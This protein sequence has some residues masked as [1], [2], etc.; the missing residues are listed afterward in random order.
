[1]QI[2]VEG[3]AT[4]RGCAKNMMESEHAEGTR[5]FLG[6]F[7]RKFSGFST[8]QRLSLYISCIQ[9]ETL[10]KECMWV[11]IKALFLPKRGRQS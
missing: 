3:G 11:R 6:R 5:K 9:N 2:E 10:K 7:S 8:E 4:W 1:M